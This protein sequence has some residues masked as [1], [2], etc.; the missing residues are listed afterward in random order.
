MHLEL[1]RQLY[2]TGKMYDEAPECSEKIFGD[3]K[4][5][6]DLTNKAGAVLQT[7]RG[8]EFLKAAAALSYAKISV[9]LR[10]RRDMDAMALINSITSQEAIY[11]LAA[12]ALKPVSLD[13]ADLCEQHRQLITPS[14]LSRMVLDEYA[15]Q[16]P[17]DPFSKR[18]LVVSYPLKGLT[19]IIGFCDTSS[20]SQAR[21]DIRRVSIG[22]AHVN[23]D[24]FGLTETSYDKAEPHIRR[25]LVE[26]GIDDFSVVHAKTPD[27]ISYLQSQFLILHVG[28][29]LVRLPLAMPMNMQVVEVDPDSELPRKGR[30]R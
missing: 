6:S 2:I 10:E 25:E 16:P 18:A 12:R 28:K 17:S 26:H 20:L 8:E 23:V 3:C 27:I 4:D 5:F 1:I 7:L 22:N 30:I 19:G 9:L 13:I 11:G 15:E 14:S 21:D 29:L 24:V